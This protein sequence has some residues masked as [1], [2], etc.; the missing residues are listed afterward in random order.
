[1]SRLD[2]ARKRGQKA[3]EQTRAKSGGSGISKWDYGAYTDVKWLS[4]LEPGIKCQFDIIPFVVT[5]DRHPDI[6][7]LRKDWEG[8]DEILDHY[9][10]YYQHRGLGVEGKTSIICPNKTWGHPCPICEERDALMKAGK[11]W[12]DEEVSELKPV[13]RTLMNVVLTDNPDE[14]LLFD[15]S[16]AW[17][18][19]NV[20]KK[21]RRMDDDEE[22]FWIADVTK[23][24]RTIRC[25]P[26]A[27]SFNSTMAGEFK[28]ID[29]IPK[30]NTF[31]ESIIDEAY[32]LDT[33][34]REYSYDEIKAIFEGDTFDGEDDDPDD[35]VEDK[36][37]EKPTPKP[38]AKPEVLSPAEKR[39]RAKASRE[40]E[41]QENPCPHGYVFGEDN[42]AKDECENCPLA[43]ECGL[44]YEELHPDV[45]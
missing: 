10:M 6:V 45:D 31:D 32:K 35:D 41:E 21:L 23:E 36:V 25:Y 33:M 5:T 1:M 22:Q 29:F 24:G 38:T 17:F 8:Q 20:Q 19:E 2:G 37:V 44:K 28:S 30:K 39:K 43:E 26:E 7:Q 4:K 42:Y 3:Q 27:S 13:A 34:L 11:D 12:K 9:V 16:Y 40:K 15:Y 14:I 18:Y